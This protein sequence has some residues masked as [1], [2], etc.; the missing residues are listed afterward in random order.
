MGKTGIRRATLGR[1]PMY[2]QY[3]LENVDSPTICFEDSK[4][5]R[6]G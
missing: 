2:L 1:L 3:I 4:G 6:T 5:S